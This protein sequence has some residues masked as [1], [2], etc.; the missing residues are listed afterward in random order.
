MELI[1]ALLYLSISNWP[2]NRGSRLTEV[3]PKMN[4]G[5]AWSNISTNKF[6]WR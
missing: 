6:K 1:P 5:R 3:Y 2:L 4:V